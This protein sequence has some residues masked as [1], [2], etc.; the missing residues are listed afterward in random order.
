MK[1][2]IDLECQTCHKIIQDETEDESLKAGDILEC[3]D[4]CHKSWKVTHTRKIKTESGDVGFLSHPM[5]TSVEIWL[6]QHLQDTWEK[7]NN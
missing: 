5:L 1:I 3:D 6:P 2:K 7:G 4:Q